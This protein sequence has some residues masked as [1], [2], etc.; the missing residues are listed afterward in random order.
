MRR[1]LFSP[2]TRQDGINK[3]RMTVSVKQPPRPSPPPSSSSEIRTRV[4]KIRKM[5][6]LII[7]IIMIIIII[8]II[9]MIMIMIM[10][11]IIIIILIIVII[12]IIP[13]LKSEAPQQF[14][15]SRLITTAHVDSI[16]SQS[17]IM[18]PGE[19]STEELKRHQQSLKRASAKEKMDSIDSSLSP[20]LLRL[21]SIH[22]SKTIYICIGNSMICSDIW[23]KYHE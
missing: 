2:V 5:R 1:N 18:V 6:I 20:G 13:D 11:I 16:T 9:I 21:V 14:A 12:I 7:I 19:R 17:S 3:L 8:I 10:I 4:K 15:A 23:H 22:I